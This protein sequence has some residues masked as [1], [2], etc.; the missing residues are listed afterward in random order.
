MQVSNMTQLL[1]AVAGMRCAVNLYGAFLFLSKKQLKEW[2]RLYFSNYPDK[3]LNVQRL[4]TWFL[5]FPYD[6]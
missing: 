6:M 2:A 1:K 4:N 3:P 5:I